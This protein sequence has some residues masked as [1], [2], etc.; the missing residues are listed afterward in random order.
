VGHPR[1][2]TRLENELNSASAVDGV[3]IEP[4]FP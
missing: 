1:L 2:C 4:G 3:E